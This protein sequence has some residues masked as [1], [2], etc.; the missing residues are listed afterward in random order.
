MT[1]HLY[2]IFKESLD[3]RVRVKFSSIDEAVILKHF[4]PEYVGCKITST[5]HDDKAEW[6]DCPFDVNKSYFYEVIDGLKLQQ[7]LY[8]DYQ[9]LRFNT[10]LGRRLVKTGR[11]FEL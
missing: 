1:Y 6:R 8:T 10:K 9:I 3:G 4:A 7:E 11:R 2:P 5:R